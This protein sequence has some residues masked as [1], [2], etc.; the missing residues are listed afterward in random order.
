MQAGDEF[1]DIWS[2]PGEHAQ[3]DDIGDTD[4]FDFNS[5]EES[6]CVEDNDSSRVSLISA[7]IVGDSCKK[8]T[9]T[10][11]LF[12]LFYNGLSTCEFKF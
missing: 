6:I 11:M 4:S 9:D 1:G 10:Y 12:V 7:G 8:V 3:G 2:E 5:S